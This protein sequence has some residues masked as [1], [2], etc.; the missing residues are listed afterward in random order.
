VGVH[1]AE[2]QRPLGRSDERVRAT[3]DAKMCRWERMVDEYRALF[4]DVALRTRM[5]IPSEQY[6]CVV[7]FVTG[8][9]AGTQGRLLEG[10]A[11]WLAE[12]LRNVEH[13]PLVWW[14]EILIARWP[15]FN[16]PGT[17]LAKLP[18]DLEPILAGDVFALLDE[19]LGQSE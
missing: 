14:A 13:T 15:Q 5:Y 11:G 3:E 19:F 7:S 2:L 1:A 12:K 8:V 6:V 17:S 10:F 18:A 9:D 4:R 16:E